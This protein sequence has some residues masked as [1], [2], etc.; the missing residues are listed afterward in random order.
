MLTSS[1][2]KKIPIFACLNDTSLVWLSQQAAD[3]H[4]EPGEYLIHEG[5]PTPFFVVMEGT[6][7]V[8]KDVMGRQTE[9][10]EH[11]PGDFFGELAI[12]MASAAPAS[13]RA[14]TA[15]HLVRL[16][17]QHLQELI[18]RSP[19]CSALILQTLNERVQ[20]VQKY[21]LNL[22]S[23]RVQIVGSKFD[24]DC[25]EIRTFLSMNRIPYEW[26]DR[27][28][29]VHPAPTDQ[30]CEVAG[31]S[32]VVDGSFCVSHPPTVR[33][34]AEALGFQTAP[35]RQNYDVV[36]IGG[37]PA[38]LRAVFAAAGRR[39]RP[40]RGRAGRHRLQRRERLVRAYLVCRVRA[41][42]LAA[43]D[44]RRP[45]RGG[46]TS[47]ASPAGRGASWRWRLIWSS[48]QFLARSEPASCCGVSARLT[49]TLL[50]P[51]S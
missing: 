51:A 14:K 3:L 23:S 43:R 40:G 26:A 17:P 37:G 44:G 21:M 36:I 7:E 39:G 49:A 15:C 45:A 10:S 46:N 34:V 47:S 2:L 30:A 12:L 35:N 25:R 13:V 16:D 31:L 8:L 9:V 1:E 19:E 33:K 29:S 5:E 24:D 20:A 48:T 41:G 18:R 4:L 27:D 32:V 22:P 6:T 28:R 38:G 42:Q 11:N 50:L